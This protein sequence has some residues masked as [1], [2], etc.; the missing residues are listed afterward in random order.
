LPLSMPPLAALTQRLRSLDCLLNE[1]G[2]ARQAAISRARSQKMT[3]IQI[4]LPGATAQ[5]ALAAGLLTPQALDR[6]LTDALKRQEAADALLSIVGR[7]M[8]CWSM[9][10]QAPWA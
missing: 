4:E 8:R 1:A 6:P 3:T 2:C 10:A 9:Y 5:A 7:R